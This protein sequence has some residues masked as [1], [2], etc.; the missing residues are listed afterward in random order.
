MRW[1]QSIRPVYQLHPSPRDYRLATTHWHGRI[2]TSAEGPSWPCRMKN[3]LMA[4]APCCITSTCAERTAAMLA[5]KWSRP[6]TV[7]LWVSEKE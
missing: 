5:L 7:L 1:Q 4:P 3:E 2:S 6:T